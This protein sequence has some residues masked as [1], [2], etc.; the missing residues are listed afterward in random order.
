MN[1]RKTFTLVVLAA[2][3]LIVVIIV[4]QLAGFVP[5]NFSTETPFPTGSETGGF[6]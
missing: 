5:R 6:Q 1:R 4:S 2:L 3:L